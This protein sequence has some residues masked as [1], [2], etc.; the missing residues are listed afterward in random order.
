[1]WGGGGSWGRG[2]E[3]GGG[4]VKM[5]HYPPQVYGEVMLQHELHATRKY[6]YL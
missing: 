6:I 4:G 1:M 2:E 5:H 3:G